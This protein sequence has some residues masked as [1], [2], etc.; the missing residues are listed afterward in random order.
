MNLPTRRSELREERLA[1]PGAVG[2]EPRLGPEGRAAVDRERL[3]GDPAT[4]VAREED[5]DVRDVPRLADPAERVSLDPRACELLV[6]E[7]LGGHP[8][9]DDPGRD[10]VD[11]N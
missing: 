1:R 6:G 2:V 9:G 8:R 11:A 7:V 5:D 4:L 10:G 3:A